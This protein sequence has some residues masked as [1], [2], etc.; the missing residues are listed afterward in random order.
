MNIHYVDVHTTINLTTTTTTSSAG[1]DGEHE[2]PETNKERSTD[3]HDNGRPT[4][5]LD[6][7]TRPPDDVTGCWQA[8]AG[9]T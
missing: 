2:L 9:A 6:D 7:V 3:T 4:Q 1:G 8:N 5:R